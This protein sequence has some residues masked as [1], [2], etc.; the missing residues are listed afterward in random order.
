M[1]YKK[2]GQTNLK[3]SVLG[4]GGCPIGGHG[5]GRVK[6]KDSIAA[7]RKAL[8]LGINFFD[9][10]DT[11]GLGHSEEVLAKALGNYRKKVIIATK[12]GVRWDPYKKKG[13]YDLSPYYLAKAVEGSLQRL[14]ID[15]IPLYQLHYPDPKTPISET[16]EALK[17]LQ[18]EGKIKYIGCSNFSP[19]LINEAQKYGRLES[20]QAS[21]N[22]IDRALE[23][24]IIPTCQKWKM[25]IFIY[26]PLSQGLLTG[27]YDLNTKFGEDDR[28]SRRSYKN[29]H[30]KKFRANLI[31]VDKLKEIASKYH[32][33]SVQVAI[34]WILDN[35][36]I[37]N[38]ILG[39]KKPEEIEENLGALGWKLAYKDRAMLI[40]TALKTYKE[41]GIK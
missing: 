38:A 37:T 1:E 15:C 24:S 26:G 16:M 33:T 19:E 2:L 11:Y 17:K 6:D 18:K 14:K 20:S 41:W 32:K 36:F 30:G 35:P 31:I 39:I 27:K 4:F 21:Y 5:W 7:I 22:I 40:K 29:F 34:R 12:G 10:A 25:S 9:T 8:R 23:K 28:R 3:V 13:Y